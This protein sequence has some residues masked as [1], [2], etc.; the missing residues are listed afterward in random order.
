M[1]ETA[2]P[3]AAVGEP[4]GFYA[5]AA[6]L[7]GLLPGDVAAWRRQEAAAKAEEARQE[8]ERAE[9]ADLRQTMTMMAARQHALHRGLAWSPERPYEHWPSVY[10]RADMMFQMQDAEARRA[11]RQAAEEA[12]LV[13][14]LHQG[15]PSPHP[16][17]PAGAPAS[18]SQGMATSGMATSGPVA[19]R[20]HPLAS[21]I[22]AALT[23]W[24]RSKGTHRASGCGCASCTP[25]PSVRRQPPPQRNRHR[26]VP[27][28]AGPAEDQRAGQ[29]QAQGEAAARKHEQDAGRQHQVSGSDVAVEDAA[30]PMTSASLGRLLTP[31]PRRRS[32]RRSLRR[33]TRSNATHPTRRRGEGAGAATQSSAHPKTPPI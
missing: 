22:R 2:E 33:S 12:G 4:A 5:D 15:V 20:A 13:D 29:A 28:T 25:T 14:L 17:E 23:R 26:E 1:T 18:R 8:S 3:W 11:D 31:A 30:P 10:A 21:R 32:T 7:P 27:M 24:A 9:R 19:A 6:D 16:V